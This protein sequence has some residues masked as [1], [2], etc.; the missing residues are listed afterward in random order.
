MTS[1]GNN[2]NVEFSHKIYNSLSKHFRIKI[3]LNHNLFIDVHSTETKGVFVFA[4][5]A[6]ETT[7]LII[8][9]ESVPSEKRESLF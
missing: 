4:F 2:N 9:K 3:T 5:F 6:I 8:S 7:K 1:K